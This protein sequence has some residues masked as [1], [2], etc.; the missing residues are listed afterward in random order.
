MLEPGCFS[1]KL[2]ARRPST[3][4]PPINAPVSSK[5]KHLSKSPSNATPISAFSEIT[6][7]AVAGRFSVISGF[8]I[9]FGKLSSGS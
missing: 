7:F 5:K 6:T 1:K 4:S 9:P 3:Y 2:V 8:G